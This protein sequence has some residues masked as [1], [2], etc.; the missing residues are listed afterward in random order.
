MRESFFGMNIAIR[1]LYTAQ[2]GLDVVNHNL[3]NVNT[4]G[5]SRQVAIQ[6]ASRPMSLSDGSG[7]LGT[8][9]DI[10]GIIRMRDE[11]IDYKYWS[12]SNFAGEWEARNKL[13]SEMEATFNEPSESGFTTILSEYFSSLQEL[14]KDPSSTAV[15]AL[16]T[17]RGVTLTKYFNST[18]AHFE[19]LQGDINNMI[20]T[21][22]EE[23]NSYAVQ[24]QQL[25]RQIY[26]AELDGSS[27]NDLRDKRT[28][29][30]DKMSRIIN[31]D[32]NEIVTGKL[33]DGKDEKRYV[34]TISGKALIDHFELSKLAVVQRKNTEKLNP[35]DIDNLYTVGWEDGNSLNVK[36]GEMRGYLDIRDGNEGRNSSPL[37]KG[38][39]YYLNRMDNFVRTFAMVLNEGY[40]DINQDGVIQPSEDT[41]GHADGW[42][43]DPD[44]TG[45]LLPSTGI[46]FFTR[47]DG[48]GK[49]MSSASFINNA[50]G[51]AAIM[52]RYEQMTARN[53]SV[54]DELTENPAFFAASDTSGEAG[55]INNLNAII[56]FRHNSEMFSEGSPEDYMKSL[57]ATLGIDAQ[58]ASRYSTNQLAMVRQLENRRLSD[59]GVS[60]DEEMA[61][62]I[63]YQQAY[64][65]AAHMINTMAEIYENLVNRV[66]V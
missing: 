33:P 14:A 2:R 35:E 23:I 56:K 22:T 46:R 36:S 49:R 29:L 6:N 47:L 25:N 9:S 63:K 1:G 28:L 15:R 13:F 24:I 20:R 34:I 18:S 59:S 10:S 38:I 64:G 58:Q 3:A 51:P 65:A 32:A 26:S 48:N 41:A 30:V 54:S 19:K 21:K 55:N 31:V 5:Y 4:P 40:I 44:K 53:F 39:P 52:S 17:E 60:I 16:V 43:S 66:G 37:Y 27:A 62:L 50:I 57:V 12:E 45:P 11:Y 8:G 7:M 42:S 61:N